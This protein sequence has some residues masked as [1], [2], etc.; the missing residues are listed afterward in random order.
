MCHNNRHNYT[1]YTPYTL[2][3]TIIDTIVHHIQTNYTNDAYIHLPYHRFL[4][5]AGVGGE[6][7]NNPTIALLPHHPITL[8][9]CLLP[10]Y[11]TTITLLLYYYYPTILL[12]FYYYYTTI[13]VPAVIFLYYYLILVSLL[14]ITHYDLLLPYYN[15]IITV[16]LP[17]YNRIF[18]LLPNHLT[19]R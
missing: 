13:R 3:D 14:P 12:L 10:Y 8:L 1:P 5:G 4:L 17:Y 7:P 15:R 18:T 6:Y 9:S 16:L 11:Y 2:I 19:I